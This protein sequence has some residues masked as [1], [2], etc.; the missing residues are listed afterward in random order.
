MAWQLCEEAFPA[1]ERRTLE[2]QTQLL[3]NS[4]YRF[5]TLHAEGELVGFMGYWQLTGFVFLEHFAVTPTARGK[6]IGKRALEKLGEVVQQTLVLEVEPPFNEMAQRRINFY[7]RS[8]F[9]LN[10][11]PYAQPP[12]SPEKPWVPL[13]LMTYPERLSL[14]AFQQ[15]KEE[16]YKVVYS[17]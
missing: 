9:H 8:G 1:E 16:L 10:P 5:I 13:L 12:Y 6:G 7:E 3:R 14:P 4:I 11:Y 15:V 2:A 17:V